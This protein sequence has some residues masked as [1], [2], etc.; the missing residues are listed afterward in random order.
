MDTCEWLIMSWR[1]KKFTI[2]KNKG[3]DSYQWKEKL[4]LLKFYADAKIETTKL[5]LDATI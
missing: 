1:P 4:K 3:H 5:Y 2:K